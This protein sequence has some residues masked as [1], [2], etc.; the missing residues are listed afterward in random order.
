M[1]SARTVSCINCFT[2]QFRTDYTFVIIATIRAACDQ[3][4]S[5]LVRIQTTFSM[6]SERV[7][8]LL[9]IGLGRAY[10]LNE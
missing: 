3:T 1:T 9:A 8:R 10:I 2:A 7:E 6:E 4:I 5:S